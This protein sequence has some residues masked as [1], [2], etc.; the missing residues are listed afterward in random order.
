MNDTFLKDHVY[1]N[2]PKKYSQELEEL[3]GDINNVLE[4]KIG[5]RICYDKNDSH[6]DHSTKPEEDCFSGFAILRDDQNQNDDIEIQLK[7]SLACLL[8]RQAQQMN[9]KELQ[10]VLFFSK[11][12][13]EIWSLEQCQKQYVKDQLGWIEDSHTVWQEE[14]NEIW[15]VINE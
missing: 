11:E 2:I 5:M 7:K 13:T 9:K 3:I 12:S 15:E 4:S 8:Y 6:M 1:M 10:E 14:C